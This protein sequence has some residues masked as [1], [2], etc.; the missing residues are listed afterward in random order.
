MAACTPVSILF[1]L[2]MLCLASGLRADVNFR[3]EEDMTVTPSVIGGIDAQSD[4]PWMVAFLEGESFDSNR[5]RFS[6][7]G[8]LIHPEWVLTA[9]HCVEGQEPADLLMAIGSR[10]LSQASRFVRASTVLVNPN[11]YNKTSSGADIALI[12]LAN[13]I[14]DIEPIALNFDIAYAKNATSGR[15]VGWGRTQFLEEGIEIPDR[16]QEADVSIFTLDFINQLNLFRNPI[17]SDFL[18]AGNLESSRGSYYGDSGGPLLV[19]N[20]NDVWEAVGITSFG[21]GSCVQEYEYISM[22]TNI[23]LFERWIRGTVFEAPLAFSGDGATIEKKL[24]FVGRHPSTGETVLYIRDESFSKVYKTNLL[25]EYLD[26][27]LNL[28]YFREMQIKDKLA[29]LFH[30]NGTWYYGMNLDAMSGSDSFFVKSTLEFGDNPADNLFHF[31]KPSSGFR[32]SNYYA[33]IVDFTGRH[34]YILLDELRVGKTYTVRSDASDFFIFSWE[35]GADSAVEIEDTTFDARE[36]RN[37]AIYLHSESFYE[38]FVY[39]LEGQSEPLNLLETID[40]ELS[41]NDPMNRSLGFHYEEFDFDQQVGGE[42]KLTV[43][44]SFDAEIELFDDRECEVLGFYDS[45][46][47]NEKEEYIVDGRLLFQSQIRVAN[48]DENTYG[49]FSLRVEPY[50]DEYT[51]QVPSRTKRA[52]TRHDDS[53]VSSRG[54]EYNVENLDLVDFPV[55]QSITIR[56][57]SPQGDSPAF[58]VFNKRDG[59]LVESTSE[60]PCETYGEITFVSEAGKAYEVVMLAN[61]EK[62]P[63]KNY[64]IS[65]KI[66]DLGSAASKAFVSD[67]ADVGTFHF[68]SPREWEKAGR[69]SV[70]F[71]AYFMGD[72]SPM[73]D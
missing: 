37:Y 54:V 27:S 45:E 44:S 43:M 62:D 36:G 51:L 41:E 50:Q 28:E 5:E 59:V 46:G 47:A 10:D 35:R 56:V 53:F 39:L 25:N 14:T 66:G 31:L 42:A 60:G 19:K 72:R 40:S 48:F 3:E 71:E 58:A 70:F 12:R 20:A 63:N 11:Y 32:H 2:V 64:E 73:W 67:K 52:I 17:H 30:L 34:L 18:P 55:G 23:A 21:F 15:I 57:D 26:R 4:Y 29:S 61:A 33:G 49:S 24:N 9:A 7:A 22:Y 16:L 8:I 65:V 6:C 13:P 38:Y 68:S 69:D 1:T